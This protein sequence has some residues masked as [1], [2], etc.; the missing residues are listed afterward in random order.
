MTEYKLINPHIEG[1]F[2]KLYPGKTPV[3]AAKSLWDNLSSNFT[4]CVPEFA[5]SLERIKDK[6]MFHFKVNESI[7]SGD[8]SYTLS[9]MS[10]K[11]SSQKKKKFENKLKKFKSKL[12]Q[13]GGRKKIKRKRKKKLKYGDDDDDDDDD[14]DSPYEHKDYFDLYLLTD[15]ILYD[16]PITYFWYYPDFYPFDY[17]FYFL[18]TWIPTISPYYILA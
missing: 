14:D 2:E 17:D 6:K 15:H 9:E 7:K 3:D 13:S 18:P 4:N 5:F 10:L 1:S 12:E 11:L 16:S 8:V